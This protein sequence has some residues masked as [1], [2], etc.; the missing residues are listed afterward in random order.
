MRSANHLR[1]VFWEPR[2]CAQTPRRTPCEAK[3]VAT[4]TFHVLKTEVLLCSPL[5][6]FAVSNRSP[7]K[8]DDSSS[9]A[10]SYTQ[11]L[12]FGRKSCKKKQYPPITCTFAGQA[13]RK[14]SSSCVRPNA[15]VEGRSLREEGD[16]RHKS[17]DDQKVDFRLSSQ[18]LLSCLPLQR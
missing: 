8:L 1:R 13:D 11:R 2:F 10:R 16:L 4:E 3:A 6:N 14:R 18:R 7:V 15:Y 12:Q 17:K 9:P 5:Q